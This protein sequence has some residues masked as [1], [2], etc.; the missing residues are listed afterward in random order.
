APHAPLQPAARVPTGKPKPARM[1]LNDLPLGLAGEA[2]ELLAR[3]LPDVAV[4]QV[5]VDANG[6]AVI[7]GDRQRCLS[8]ALELRRIHGGDLRQLVDPGRDDVR[9]ALT[10]LGQMQTRRLARQ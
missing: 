1:T 8:R 9:L 2:T 7:A 3:P 4:G 10:L 6:Q 5:A